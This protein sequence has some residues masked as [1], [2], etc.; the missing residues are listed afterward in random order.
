MNGFIRLYGWGIMM[1]FHMAM[2]TLALIFFSCLFR[3][4]IG[5]RSLSIVTLMQMVAVAMA[6]AIIESLIFPQHSTQEGTALVHRTVLWAIVCNLGFIGGSVAFGWFTG[7]PGWVG[8]AL[9]VIL[10]IGLC[11]MWFGENV[12]LKKDTQWLNHKLHQYQ[13][14]D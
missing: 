5:E 8:V 6:V 13:S 3:W 4:G 11:A 14:R 1:K 12:A 7:G 10:Q 2:Y 9:V